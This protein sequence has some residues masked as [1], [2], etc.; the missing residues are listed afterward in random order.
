MALRD[1]IVIDRIEVLEDGQVQIRRVRRVFDGNELLGEQYHRSVLEPGD[2]TT[3]LSPRVKKVT[4]AVWDIQT[5]SL[6]KAK[7]VQGLNR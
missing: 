5:V 1:E 4:D 7:R 3:N 6:Y 2:D